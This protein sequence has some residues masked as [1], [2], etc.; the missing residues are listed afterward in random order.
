[1]FVY[2]R[3]PDIL[4]SLGVIEK[5][6]VKSQKSKLQ[7]KTQNKNLS[8]YILILIFASWILTSSAFSQE[9]VKWPGVD[10]NVVEKFC[11]GTGKAGLDAFFIN[12]DQGDLLLLF[13]SW[14][15]AAGD[16]WP[17]SAG[18]KLFYE[19]RR[20]GMNELFSDY[21]AQ[22]DNLLTRLVPG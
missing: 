1:M 19:K 17:D 16:L 15:G 7:T 18:G 11:P 21:F 12:T 4:N 22:R 3:R 20:R 5:S 10:V 9:Q 2:K 8:G 14:P 13:F 6:K